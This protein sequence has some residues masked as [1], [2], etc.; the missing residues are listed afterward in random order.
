MTPRQIIRLR[1]SIPSTKPGNR[2]A[3]MGIAEFAKLAGVSR[4]TVFRWETGR[5]APQG[6][7]LVRLQEIQ[8]KFR[9]GK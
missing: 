5:S 3:C 8:A 6:K 2:E 7:T 1:H 9:G 4:M